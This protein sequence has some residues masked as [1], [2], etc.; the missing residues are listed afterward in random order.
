MAISKKFVICVNSGGYPAALEPRK[1]YERKPDPPALKLGLLRV[2]DESGGDYLYPA[3]LF[4]AVSLP[5]RLQRKIAAAHRNR[6][7]AVRR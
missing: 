3:N 7:V 4:E 1:L 5:Q 2:V 6:A